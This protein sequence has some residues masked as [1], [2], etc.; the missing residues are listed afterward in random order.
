MDNGEDW[1]ARVGHVALAEAAVL[2]ASGDPDAAAPLFARAERTF[3]R[4]RL[5]GEEA[6][7]AR[8]G[9][10]AGRGTGVGD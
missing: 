8:R 5:V 6:E 2:A 4:Y 9:S 7:A 10:S 1:R 3:A